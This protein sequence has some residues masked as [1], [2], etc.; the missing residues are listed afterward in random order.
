MTRAQDSGGNPPLDVGRQLQQAQGIRDVRP[1]PPDPPGKLVVG[2]T[3]VIEQLL[4]G[5]GLLQRVE[6]LPMQI[7]DQRIPEQI[8]VP[9]LPHDRRD[10]GQ[11]CTLAGA[12]PPLT[13]HDLEV[14]GHDRTD[15]D[16]L[17]QADRAY[18]VGELLKSLLVEHLARLAGVWRDGAGRQLVKVGACPAEPIQVRVPRGRPIAGRRVAIRRIRRRR[19]RDQGTEPLAQSPLLLRHCLCLSSFSA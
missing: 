9:G 19:G 3:E 12:P 6:L 13:H 14:P 11:P 7:L 15:D 16:W 17:Q 10:V 4:V 2:R 18:R 5:G 8:I 1:G